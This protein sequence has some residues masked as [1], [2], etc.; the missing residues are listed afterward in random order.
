DEKGASSWTATGETLSI[1]VAI[2]GVDPHDAALEVLVCLGQALW[3]TLDQ[4]KRREWLA[5]L[6]TE[7]EHAV[8]GEIDEDALHSKQKLMASPSAARSPH[9][10]EEYA[11]AAFA[12][13]VAE[14]VHALWHDVTIRT[15]PS[16]LP[17]PWL[18]RRFE[19][20]LRWFPPDPGRKLFAETATWPHEPSP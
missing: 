2:Q 4:S 3:E 1:A 7:I 18:R 19:L 12:G 14:Y 10:L 16:H 8:S 17:A 11:Q 20:M 13:T 5:L 15:G 6:N 9:R